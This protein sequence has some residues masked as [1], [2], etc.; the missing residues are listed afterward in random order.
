MKNIIYSTV[1]AFLVLFTSMTPSS[2][3]TET[4]TISTWLWNPYEIVDN[5][6]EVL[7]FLEQNGV[8]D[9]YLQV[10]RDIAI[11]HYQT[12]I[13]QA[14]QRK[15]NVHALDGA[16]SWATKQGKRQYDP[17]ISWLRN[18]QAQSTS[19]QRFKG[20]HLDVEP[21]LVQEWNSNR[22]KTI[23]YYQQAL[24]S[25]Q[26]LA[27][28]LKLVYSND[29]PFW[30]D[31]I[32]FNNKPYGKGNLSEWLIN[33]SDFITIMAYRNMAD[34]PN[35]IIEL[36]KNEINYALKQHKKVVIGVETMKSL[37]GSHI[38]FADKGQ[39]YMEKELLKV[40]VAYQS[41]VSFSGFAYHHYASWKQLK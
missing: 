18:Y 21:Y 41:T 8:T 30:F 5:S 23:E 40:E 37:E 9:L 34:G 29:I 17:V 3:A 4:K 39:S 15:I 20:I 26:T 31:E 19:E 22:Q 35:G 24:I 25:F 7:L 33:Q 36:V 1:L 14:S 38:S 32:S 6:I 2:A 27:K 28:E 11:R 13:A 16:P 12:F 10:D